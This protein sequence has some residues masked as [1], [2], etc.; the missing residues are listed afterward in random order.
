MIHLSSTEGPGR[1]EIRLALHNISHSWDMIVGNRISKAGG[2][3]LI[4]VCWYNHNVVKHDAGMVCFF[5]LSFE[6]SSNLIVLLVGTFE[7]PLLVQTMVVI[8]LATAYL[9]NASSFRHI[10]KMFLYSS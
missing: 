1:A 4:V 9:F 3:V 5:S 7:V 10:L 2:G 6:P 8:M